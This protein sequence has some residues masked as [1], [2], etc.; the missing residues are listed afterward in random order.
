[1]FGHAWSEAA[2][3][4]PTPMLKSETLEQPMTLLNPYDTRLGAT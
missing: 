3:C 4:V 1:M 2:Y